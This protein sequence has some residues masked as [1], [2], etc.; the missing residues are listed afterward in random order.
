MIVILK[1]GN[2]SLLPT[3]YNFVAVHTFNLF[4]RMILNRLSPLI[5]DIIID[6]QAG[7]TP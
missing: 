7:F 5:E 2:D 1:P 6:Q 4:E 3:N